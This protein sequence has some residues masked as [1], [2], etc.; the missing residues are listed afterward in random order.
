MIRRVKCK[1]SPLSFFQDQIHMLQTY[2]QDGQLRKNYVRAIVGTIPFN[3]SNIGFNSALVT[4]INSSNVPCLVFDLSII[5]LTVF[6]ALH[7]QFVL[8]ILYLIPINPLSFIF[9]YICY[10]SQPVW[11]TPQSAFAGNER[12]NCCWHQLPF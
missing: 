9:I 8:L 6:F 3:Q 7:F 2:L 5:H 12:F 1:C 4:A 10:Y 11:L